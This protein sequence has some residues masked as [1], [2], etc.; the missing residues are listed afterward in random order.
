MLGDLGGI[1][2]SYGLL[3]VLFLEVCIGEFQYVR[4]LL[5]S[6]FYEEKNGL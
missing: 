4:K 5:N 3:S 6:M 1:I 2:S